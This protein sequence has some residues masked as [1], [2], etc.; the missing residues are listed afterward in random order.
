[1]GEAVSWLVIDT[2]PDRSQRWLGE[3]PTEVEAQNP[4]RNHYR[5]CPIPHLASKGVPNSVA[6]E[7]STMKKSTMD[8]HPTCLAG[9][10][11]NGSVP[12][13]G[14]RMAS[15]P[16]LWTIG[17]LFR[18][19]TLRLPIVRQR[20]PRLGCIVQHKQDGSPRLVPNA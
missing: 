6:E 19:Q 9:A 13:L 16:S 11:P 10:I 18:T 2:L 3:Y 20:N 8:N 1:V 7:G 15:S 14:E 17:S 12:S 5:S 4:R